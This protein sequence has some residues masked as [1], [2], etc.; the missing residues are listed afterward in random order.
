M[1]TDGEINDDFGFAYFYDES[2]L[3]LNLQLVY[4]YS[5]LCLSVF[6]MC[7]LSYYLFNMLISL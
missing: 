3:G 5:M 7:Y 1:D 6:A 2:E 4:C